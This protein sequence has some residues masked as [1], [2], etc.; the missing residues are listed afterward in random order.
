MH[1]QGDRRSSKSWFVEALMV[2]RFFV[3]GMLATILHMSLA[4]VLIQRGHAQPITANLIG[5]SS[6][7][8]LSF[9]GQ[10]FWTFRSQRHW[11]AAMWRFAA[12]SAIAFAVNNALLLSIVDNQMLTAG[13]ATVLAA[14]IIPV[15]T[16]LGNRLWA[17]V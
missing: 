8:V 16:Y 12:V 9:V 2:Y 1:G 15:I 17:L 6:A 3:I 4:W 13:N 14:C 11:V 5:F 10:Y 7:F